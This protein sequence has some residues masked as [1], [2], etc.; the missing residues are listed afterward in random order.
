[1]IGLQGAA[2]KSQFRKNLKKSRS[3]VR[4]KPQE[5]G[6]IEDESPETVSDQIFM[7]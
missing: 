6:H 4:K 7:Q 3:K 5:K 2:M 1:M